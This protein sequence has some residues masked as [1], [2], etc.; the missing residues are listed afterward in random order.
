MRVFQKLS[1]DWPDETS[2]YSKKLLDILHCTLKRLASFG[3][4]GLG[5]VT[6]H[7]QSRT[8]WISFGFG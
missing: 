7:W 8:E 3:P 2:T 4:S 6:E 5:L 1:K